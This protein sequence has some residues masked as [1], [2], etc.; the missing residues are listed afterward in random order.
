MAPNHPSG[1]FT[2][3]HHWLRALQSLA[4]AVTEEVQAAPHLFAAHTVVHVVTETIEP[5]HAPPKKDTKHIPNNETLKLQQQQQPRSRVLVPNAALKSSASIQRRLQQQGRGSSSLGDRAESDEGLEGSESSGGGLGEGV[6]SDAGE[7]LFQSRASVEDTAQELELWRFAAEHKWGFQTTKTRRNKK[8]ERGGSNGD[9]TNGNTTTTSA[10]AVSSDDDD[11]ASL[12][13][14]AS[15]RR[16]SRESLAALHGFELKLHL[17][18]DTF[19]SMAHLVGADILVVGNSGFGHVAA[20]YSRGIVFRVSR[21]GC[22]EKDVLKML[23][24]PFLNLN[25]KDEGNDKDEEPPSL[26]K[27]RADHDLATP[28]EVALLAVSRSI[29]GCRLRSLVQ[30]LRSQKLANAGVFKSS[31]ATLPL[32]P[33]SLDL[34]PLETNLARSFFEHF[35][36]EKAR[37]L[38]SRHIEWG[39]REKNIE[40]VLQQL[41]R[42]GRTNP[43]KDKPL[44]GDPPIPEQLKPLPCDWK[45]LSLPKKDEHVGDERDGDGTHGEYSCASLG[46]SVGGWDME[47]M[48][49]WMLGVDRRI[50]QSHTGVGNDTEGARSGRGSSESIDTKKVV[51]SKQTALRVQ[52]IVAPLP[53]VKSSAHASLKRRREDEFE[54]MEGLATDGNGGRS[55]GTSAGAGGGGRHG[56]GRGDTERRTVVVGKK[57]RSRGRPRGAAAAAATAAAARDHNSGDVSNVDVGGGSNVSVIGDGSAASPFLAQSREEEKGQLPGMAQ[58]EKAEEHLTLK[59]IGAM[60]IEA[61][62]TATALMAT[63]GLLEDPPPSTVPHKLPPPPPPPPPQTPSPPPLSPGLVVPPLLRKFSLAAPV[64]LLAVALGLWCVRRRKNSSNN[65]NGIIS[66]AAGRPNCSKLDAENGGGGSTLPSQRPRNLRSV[67]KV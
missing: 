10:G 66:R 38:Q 39:E 53:T 31:S 4:D 61:A 14:E 29:F 15:S 35:R 27:L 25:Q 32:V 30:N 8:S 42:M 18:S 57:M 44:A 50:T 34:S 3:I 16:G 48:W 49:N 37:F 59:P 51:E 46:P 41:I 45:L 12:E 26:A 23:P 67:L 33:L 11:D 19:E 63:S 2:P 22:D 24:L 56:A 58:N 52:P 6:Q 28:S 21:L 54:A 65:K 20:S 36:V 60:V 7:T 40:S 43:R 13:S 5:Y 64:S 55:A 17:D 9:I 47:L 62:S 1:R